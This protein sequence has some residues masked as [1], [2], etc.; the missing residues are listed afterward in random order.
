MLTKEM[1][2]KKRILKEV[3]DYFMVL[4][5]TFM[6]AIGVELFM[7]PYQL[8]TGGVAGISALIYYATGLQVPISYALINIT[9]LIF[10]ARILGL[11]FCIKSLFGFGSITMWLTVL[12][13]ILRD[14]V[15]HQLPQILGNELFMAC[16]LS[17]ILEGLGLAICFYNNGS[18]GGTDI[19]IAIVNKYMNVSLGQMM[20]ICDIIIVSSSYFIF[21]DV[22]RIIFGFILLVVAAMTLDY[23]MR[24]LC[25]AVEFKVFSRNYSAIAD[26]IAEEGF[27]VTVLSGEGWYT[28]SER[29][30]VMCVCSRRYAET[31]MRAIQSVDPFCFVSVT[32]ALGVYG[33]GFETMKTKVK[34]Q[35]PILVFATNSKNKLAEVRSILG[36]RFEIR[37]LKEVGCNAELPE[38]HDTL[39]ENALEKAR[40]VNKYYGF[41]C[42]ADDTGLEVDA[43]DG[44]PG[45]YSARYANIEDADYNDPLVGADHDSEANMR[46]LLHKLDGKENRKARFRTSIALI[47]KG[48]E[49][50]FD[51]I[52]N[53]SILTEKHGTEGFGYDPVFRPE[54]YDKSF[55]ELG[56]DIKNRISHRALATEKLAGFLLK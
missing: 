22:Q 8:T 33:E 29:N 14:P 39:E 26:R 36:D 27:G 5:G 18:T 35:K 56:G 15:T 51:G 44:A 12:D 16:V 21:H 41:D 40:Y 4:V 49:Y 24:K 47:Y 31:I 20:M 55:A 3:H 7:L 17:G 13:P 34:N 28:K 10:G 6:Y 11:N 38:T 53:G 45:V 37:S 32:N 30:V 43:L 23:F 1:L 25:Q 9:F 42:F 52:I 46:K 54:G 50:F 2:N 19:I 48:K